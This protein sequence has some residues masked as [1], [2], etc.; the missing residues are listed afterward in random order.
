MA[1]YKVKTDIF[2]A[3]STLARALAGLAGEPNPA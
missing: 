2:R 1:A 3:R